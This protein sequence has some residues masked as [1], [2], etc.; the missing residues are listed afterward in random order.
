MCKWFAR[1]YYYAR[2]ARDTKKTDVYDS[3]QRHRSF[4]MWARDL[5][6]Q[7]LSAFCAS[8]LQ[9]ISAVGSSH[10]FSKAVLFLSLALLGLVGSEHGR[11]LL[12]V[13][14]GSEMGSRPVLR[15]NAFLQ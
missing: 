3:R 13:E 6:S 5:V 11:H 2:R 15:H 7:S 1:A 9:N 14:F 4:S 8:S 12:Q 10:S